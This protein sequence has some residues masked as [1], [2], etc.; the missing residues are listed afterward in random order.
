MGRQYLAVGTSLHRLDSTIVL[1]RVGPLQ[2]SRKPGQLAAASIGNK[3]LFGG[4]MYNGTVF[5]PSDRL[6]VYDAYANSWS[7]RK[8]ICSTH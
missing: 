4:G 7:Y 6:D 2:V 3:V 1:R 8:P 5:T